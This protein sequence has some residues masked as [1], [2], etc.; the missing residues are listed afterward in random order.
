[1]M[2][3]A[4]SVWSIN[5]SRDVRNQDA[6]IHHHPATVVNLRDVMTRRKQ[7]SAVALAGIDAVPV[8]AALPLPGPIPRQRV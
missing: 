3:A 6:R 1:M 5:S 8:A 7:R 2:E 4:R